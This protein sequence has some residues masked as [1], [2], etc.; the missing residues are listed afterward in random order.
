MDDANAVR[1]TSFHLGIPGRHSRDRAE[2]DRLARKVAAEAGPGARVRASREIVALIVRTGYLARLVGERLPDAE[3]VRYEAGC[4]ALDRGW[5]PGLAAGVKDIVAADVPGF[6]AE[7]TGCLAEELTRLAPAVMDLNRIA[8]GDQGEPVS[9]CAWAASL[10][11]S[12]SS[13]VWKTAIRQAVRSAKPTG[14][15]LPADSR[16]REPLI[17]LEREAGFRPLWR[18]RPAGGGP[19][20]G[21]VTEEDDS[22][23]DDVCDSMKRLPDEYRLHLGAYQM[24][25]LLRTPPVARSESGELF[26]TVRD[27]AGQE[28]VR[29]ALRSLAGEGGSPSRPVDEDALRRVFGHWTVDDLRAV[30]EHDGALSVIRILVSAAASRVKAMRDT[31]ARASAPALMAALRARLSPGDRA[32]FETTVAGWSASRVASFALAVNSAVHEPRGERQ[33]ERAEK[34]PQ[35]F[36]AEEAAVDVD[37]LAS[38]AYEVLVRR[39]LDSV[40]SGKPD[41]PAVRAEAA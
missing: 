33:R 12:R 31:D 4:V 25:S 37:L 32:V 9:A 6:R 34:Y 11:R 22:R 10:V 29:E 14:G 30:T 2:A 39:M 40:P 24:T 18:G 36:L 3:A 28:A 17:A 1:N 19:V 5:A 15:L 7:V 13:G 27:R 41:V 8:Y 21:E 20:H 35:R 38:A 16:G 23:T 26:D